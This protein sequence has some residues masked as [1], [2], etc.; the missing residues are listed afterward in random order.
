MLSRSYAE[1]K[2]PRGDGNFKCRPIEWN[3]FASGPPG[4]ESVPSPSEEC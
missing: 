3:P 1:P 2:S 4:R